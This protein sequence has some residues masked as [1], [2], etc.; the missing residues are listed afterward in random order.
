MSRKRDLVYASAA[1]A[2]AA[3]VFVACYLE[4]VAVGIFTGVIAPCARG[5]EWWISTFLW[6]SY[7]MP[8]WGGLIAIFSGWKLFRRLRNKASHHIRAAE[9]LGAMVRAESPH[10]I[11]K[12]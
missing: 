6:I 8:L 2:A 9:T 4:L 3:L 5:P 7:A 11:T 10:V 12:H 1:V